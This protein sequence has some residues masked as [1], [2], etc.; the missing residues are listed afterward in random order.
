LLLISK[1]VILIHETKTQSMGTQSPR[2][3]SDE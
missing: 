3:G 1:E 2:D